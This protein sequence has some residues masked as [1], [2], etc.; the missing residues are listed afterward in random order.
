MNILFK[1]FLLAVAVL[2]ARAA[3]AA[4]VDVLIH[5]NSCVSTTPGVTPV[6][7]QY[8]I[9][10]GSTTTALNVTCPISLP[11]HNYTSGYIQMTAW[12]RNSPD[13]VF[14][15]FSAT[16]AFGN[17]PYSTRATA[18]YNQGN[19]QIVG[20]NLGGNVSSPYLYLTCH[21][22]MQSAALGKS[23]LSSI[24]LAASY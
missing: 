20:A 10:N 6:Y 19:P 3:S 1:S 12:T 15:N 14:C 11:N 21:I 13:A 23:Y 8:G 9:Y 17:S 4:T 5:G 22:P 24:Y 18:Y 7:T 16:D 2:G